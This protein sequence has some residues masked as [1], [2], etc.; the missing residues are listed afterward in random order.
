[1]RKIILIGEPVAHSRSPLMQN[2]A[3][4]ELGLPA[5]YE[6]VNTTSA[7]LPER[8]AALRDA[9]YLGANVTLPHKQ[10]VIPLLDRLEDEAARIGAVNTIYK[11]A[12]GELVGANTDAPALIMDLAEV[13]FQPVNRTAVVLGASGAA[14]AAAFALAHAGVATLVVANRT[15]ARAEELLADLLLTLTDEQGLTASGEAPPA[16]LALELTAT[17]LAPYLI[18]DG[19]L[20]NA[21]ALGWREGETPLPNPPVGASNLVYDMVYRQ[22]L[23]LRDSATQGA[24]VRD[25][26]GMLLYQGALA[27]QRWTGQ[28]APLEVMRTALFG[29]MR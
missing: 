3:L 10:A 2:A 5:R 14:R 12:Q 24:A 7:E 28:S 6:A 15:L 23:L 20:V 8:V 4:A 17:D 13:G 22:T 26:L 19:L 25:G 11:G 27:L 16:M 21:T 9:D 29:A 18:G 1:M